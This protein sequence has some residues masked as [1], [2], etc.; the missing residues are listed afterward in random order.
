MFSRHTLINLDLLCFKNL[1]IKKFSGIICWQI[2][3]KLKKCKK[4][5][6][7]H[8]LYSSMIRP[9]LFPS[10][11]HHTLELLNIDF[12]AYCLIPT[13]KSSVFELESEL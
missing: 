11:V 13:K 8:S 6:K 10:G 12:L 4:E 9:C 7:E 5:N 1:I 2:E 3:F